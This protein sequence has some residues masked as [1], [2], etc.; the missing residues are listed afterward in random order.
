[1][2]SPQRSFRS[3]NSRKYFKRTRAS[4]SGRHR[5]MPRHLLRCWRATACGFENRVW[6][7]WVAK[8]PHACGL[9]DGNTGRWTST[10]DV[11][12]PISREGVTVRARVMHA[13][14]RSRQLEARIL[15]FQRDVIAAFTAED[16]DEAA[17]R[18][19]ER[20]P[21]LHGFA[22]VFKLGTGGVSTLRA[23]GAI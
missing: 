8:P 9:G 10:Q 13:T 11:R 14:L 16:D 3:G 19:R 7:L 22:V 6:H 18:F 2:R 23:S 5:P 21:P 17:A 12:P 15:L 1:M 4:R 20:P